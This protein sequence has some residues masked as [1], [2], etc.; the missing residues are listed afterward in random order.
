M[1]GQHDTD[2]ERLWGGGGMRITQQ[3]AEVD[4]MVE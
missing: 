4:L 1:M 3:I 2:K